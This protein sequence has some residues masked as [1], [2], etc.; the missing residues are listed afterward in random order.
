MA[1]KRGRRKKKKITVGSVLSFIVLLIAIG[2]FIYSA[3]RLYDIYHGRA[4]GDKEYEHLQDIG[5]TTD[6]DNR[7]RVDF[8][9]LWKVNKDIIAWIRFDEPSVINYP[10]VQGTDN[11][12]YLSHTISGFENTYGAIFMNYENKPD[13]SDFNTIIYGHRMNNDTMFGQLKSY[14]EQDFWDK[15][16]Y[17]YI[18]TPDGAEHKYRIFGTGTVHQESDTY[19]FGFADDAD[20]QKYLDFLKSG[21]DYDSSVKVDVNS[22]IVTLSTCTPASDE[23]RYVVIG[24]LE[25]TIE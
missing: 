1:K 20:K 10:V 16:P 15:Y 6:E 12:E 25:E 4:E 19:Q 9:E 14:K 13:F 7:Y 21:V 3:Y 5:I 8:D 23:N 2:V 24:M 11:V 18:Y 22:K 17:F